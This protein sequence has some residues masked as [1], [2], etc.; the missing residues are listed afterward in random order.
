M[1]AASVQRQPSI[2]SV[3]EDE[4]HTSAS[5]QAGLEPR[6]SLA[7]SSLRFFDGQRPCPSV[8][9]ALP[10]QAPSPHVHDTSR[11]KTRPRGLATVCARFSLHRH[12]VSANKDGQFD[13]LYQLPNKNIS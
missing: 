6:A 1:I 2:R 9:C 10:S 12:V 8:S 5:A 11:I 7:R 13:A 3:Y 4:R